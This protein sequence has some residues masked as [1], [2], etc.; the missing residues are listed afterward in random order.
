MA[1]PDRMPR[2]SLCFESRLASGSGLQMCPLTCGVRRCQ[3]ALKAKASRRAAAR[4]PLL[5]NVIFVID[6][7]LG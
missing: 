4:A 2:V 3:L 6:Y 7:Y 5:R 1:T